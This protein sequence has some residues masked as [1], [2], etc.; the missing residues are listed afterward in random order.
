M[1]RD[2]ETREAYAKVRADKARLRKERKA[3]AIAHIKAVTSSTAPGKRQPRERNNAFLAFVRR[4]PCAVC[5]SSPV[6]AAHT[7]FGNPAVGRLNPGMGAKPSDR[8]ATPLCRT[9]HEA[10]HAHGNERAWWASVG[11]DPDALSASLYAAF[12]AGSD[13]VQMVARRQPEGAE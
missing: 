6:D 9:H 8:F 1:I 12:L 7:R 11:I 5:G 3:A 4:H 13:P 10:Q 2:A